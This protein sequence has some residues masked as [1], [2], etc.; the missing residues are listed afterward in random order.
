MFISFILKEVIVDDV[1]MVSQNVFQLSGLIE[2]MSDYWNME[3][4][5]WIEDSGMAECIE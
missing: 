1:L 5:S 2:L 4:K 3:Q